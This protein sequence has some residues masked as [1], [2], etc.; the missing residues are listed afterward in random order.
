MNQCIPEQYKLVLKEKDRHLCSY[1]EAENQVLGFN[2]MQLGEY[3]A[4]SWGLPET[5][6]VPI[7]Q[8]HEFEDREVENPH[9]DIIARLLKLSSLFIELNNFEDKRFFVAIAQL[10]VLVKRWGFKDRLQIDDIVKQIHSQTMN[11]FP[12]FDLE[13]AEDKDYFRLIEDARNAL[14]HLSSDFMQQLFEQKKL[15]QS[16]SEQT[17]RDSLTNLLNFH[18]FHEALDREIQRAKRYGH[19]LGLIMADIDH[20]KAVNDNYGHLAGDYVLKEVAGFLRNL[21]R[22]SDI[23]ARYGGEEFAIILPETSQ[24]DTILVAERLRESIESLSIEY[25]NQTLAV[26]LSFGIACLEPSRSKSKTDLIKE[27][28]I[29]LYLAKREGRNRCRCFD[30]QPC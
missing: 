22:T 29:A 17:M 11:V 21:L 13:I 1:H 28:D 18:A 16:L 15:I 10:D 12:L 2:H 23:I 27:A 20:F 5:F 8:H 26:N 25:E 7:G 4:Q 9:I 6:S 24:K 14:I 3:L 30:A 19:H